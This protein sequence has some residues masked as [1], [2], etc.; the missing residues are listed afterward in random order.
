MPVLHRG[1]LDYLASTGA[2]VVYALEASDLPCFPQLVREMRALSISEL[3]SLL[4]VLGY[5]VKKFSN[6]S[7][8]SV[9]KGVEIYMPE[10]DVTRWIKKEYLLDRD[11]VWGS[12]FLRWDWTKGTDTGF[13]QPQADRVIT[14]SDPQYQLLSE[15]MTVLL[16]EAQKSS[17]WWRQVAGIAVA[18]GGECIVAYNKHFP[19]EHAPYFDGDPRDS[20]K[21]GEFIE[22][23]TALHAERGIIAEAARRGVALEGAE[24]YSTTFPCSDC[25]NQIAVSGIQSVV[26]TGGYSNLNGVET[27]R[28]KRVAL[29]YL[30]L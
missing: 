2:K 29:V 14:K 25:A 11:V 13:V 1:Y 22:I 28:G 24:L 17:D 30:E 12:W 26:F 6:L 10:D 4:H 27:L 9:S 19:H 7:I 18:Q 23:S 5:E 3:A 8:S 21:P 15:R 16:K 20:F